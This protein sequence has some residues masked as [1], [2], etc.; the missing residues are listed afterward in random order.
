M[1]S[2]SKKY[3]AAMAG[4]VAYPFAV[5]DSKGKDFLLIL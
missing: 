2:G 4:N 5:F 3:Y 1:A